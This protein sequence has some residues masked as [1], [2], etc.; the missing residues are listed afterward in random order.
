VVVL[1]LAGPHRRAAL[2]Y[3]A[4]DGGSRWW[5]QAMPCSGDAV[6]LAVTGARS[7]PSSGLIWATRLAGWCRREGEIAG[8]AVWLGTR[9]PA[10]VDQDLG[11]RARSRPVLSDA[12]HGVGPGAGHRC[13]SGFYRS[14]VAPSRLCRLPTGTGLWLLG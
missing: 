12:G 11:L 3:P 7:G 8:A 2:R 6:S 4:V 9:L 14:L 5:V 1:R 13:S 10:A